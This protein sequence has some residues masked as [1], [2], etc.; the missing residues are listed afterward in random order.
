VCRYNSGH[1][2]GMPRSLTS[3]SH[4]TL[5]PLEGA[6]N[7][8]YVG[9]QV[10]RPRRRCRGTGKAPQRNRSGVAPCSAEGARPPAGGTPFKPLCRNRVQQFHPS[11]RPRA[12][13][14]DHGH[15]AYRCSSI[16]SHHDRKS[17]ALH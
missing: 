13:I 11:L 12:N 17:C 16:H 9:K 8:P 14:F 3:E 15:A 2:K 4:A 1:W 7:F 6:K 10:P 5:H